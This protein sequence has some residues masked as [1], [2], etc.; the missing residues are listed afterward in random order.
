MQKTITL[1]VNGQQV[2]FSVDTAAYNR[3]VNELLPSNKVAP[4]E[5]FLRRTVE[6]DSREAVKTLLDLPGASVQLAMALVE[7]FMPDLEIEVGK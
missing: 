4:A 5:N 1:T 6:P 2:T 7:A 3:Y